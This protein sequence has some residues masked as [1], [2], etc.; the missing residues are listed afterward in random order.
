[1]RQVGSFGRVESLPVLLAKGGYRTARVGKFHVA[2]ESVYAF[3]QVLGGG[4]ANDPASIGRSPV[5]MAE[6]SRQVIESEDA[7]PFFLYFASDDPHRSN[8]VLPD[9]NPTFDTWPEPNDFGN[10]AGGYPGIDPVRYDPDSVIVP[11]FLPDTEACRAELAQYYQSV[12]RLDQG[13]GHLIK[14]LK[15]AG[16]YENTLILYLSD[17]GIAFPGAKTTVYEPGIHLPLIIRS[18]GTMTSGTVQPAMVTWA[19][20]TPTLLE[21]AGIPYS[22]EMF[23]GR[24]FKN[25]LAGEPMSGWNEVFIS[26]TMH[27]ITMYYPMRAVRNRQFKLI[28]NL[29]HGLSF[30]SALDLI[31][32]PTWRS[33]VNDDDARLG[34]RR[35]TDFLHRPEFELYNLEA[36]PGEVVNLANDPDYEDIQSRLIERLKHHQSITGDP[37]IHKW[38]YE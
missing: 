23:D 35:I 13:V 19:D 2:P 29:A 37:W 28:H 26:H 20:L 21:V 22:K 8:A 5:E 17:N 14:I 32:S 9:G 18:P 25:G 10:R 36:D 6:L 33:A 11:D 34:E 27:E 12:S 15:Q 38:D 3:D 4:A 31:Q 30:P 1:M 24:S 7:R 16:V